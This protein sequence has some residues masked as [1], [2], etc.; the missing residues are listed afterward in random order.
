ML[1]YLKFTSGQ[2]FQRWKIFELFQRIIMY[3]K[4]INEKPRIQFELLEKEIWTLFYTYHII[5]LHNI[6][7]IFLPLVP[8]RSYS[9]GETLICY[10]GFRQVGLWSNYIRKI[11]QRIFI[12]RATIYFLNPYLELL[13]RN[14]TLIWKNQNIIK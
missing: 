3:L 14:Q 1:C 4:E 9:S 12:S 8:I 11:F 7:V 6:F 10:D 5:I 2:R 13:W